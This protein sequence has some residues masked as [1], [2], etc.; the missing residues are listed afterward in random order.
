MLGRSH[1]KVA[2]MLTNTED[3]LLAFRRNSPPPLVP[4]LVYES[5]G[6]GEQRNSMPH[7]RRRRVPRPCRLGQSY[8]PARCRETPPLTET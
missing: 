5:V 2:A 7:R 3:D 4:E 8:S 6:T 1:P